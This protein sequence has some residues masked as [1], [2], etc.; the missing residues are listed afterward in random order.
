MDRRLLEVIVEEEPSLKEDIVEN[1]DIECA[2]CVRTSD[3]WILCRFP[4]FSGF[5]SCYIACVIVCI[6]GILV[7]IALGFWAVWRPHVE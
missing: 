2:C 1:T 6:L 5:T 4:C 7:A 3:D